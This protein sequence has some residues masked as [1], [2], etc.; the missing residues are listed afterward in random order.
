MFQHLPSS[1]SQS[2]YLNVFL[3]PLCFPFTSPFIFYICMSYV[4]GVYRCTATYQKLSTLKQHTSII[5]QF[6]QVRNQGITAQMCPLLRFFP[7]FSYEGSTRQKSTFTQQVVN[8]MQLPVAGGRHPR[9]KGCPQL[10]A[11]WSSP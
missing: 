7:R 1:Y 10:P 8:R 6:L 4:F 5:A 9:A 2:I 11:M 3:I